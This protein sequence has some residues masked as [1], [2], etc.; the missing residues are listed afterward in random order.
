MSGNKYII[1]MANIDNSDILVEPMKRQKDEEIMR[2]YQTLLQRLH[3]ANIVPK[4]HVLD[5]EV[6]E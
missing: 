6:S 1:V 4:K 2:A 3:R 5:N